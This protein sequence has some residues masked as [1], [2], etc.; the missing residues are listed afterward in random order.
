MSIYEKNK[1][2]VWYRLS[3]Q[4]ESKL[5]TPNDEE[6]K[7]QEILVAQNFLEPMKDYPD[8]YNYLSRAQKSL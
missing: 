7:R 8:R 6:V 1:Y 2:L 4:I 3:C 5:P